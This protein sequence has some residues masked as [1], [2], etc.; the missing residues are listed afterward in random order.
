MLSL[1]WKTVQCVFLGQGRSSI[2]AH[3][4][5]PLSSLSWRVVVP[6]YRDIDTYCCHWLRRDH[7][8]RVWFVADSKNEMEFDQ[9]M[10]AI[11]STR[12]VLFT[13]ANKQILI[14]YVTF[15]SIQHELHLNEQ[16]K[17]RKNKR[18]FCT[19]FNYP[20]FRILSPF[21]EAFLGKALLVRDPL[22]AKIAFFGSSGHP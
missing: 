22:W 8:N 20:H 12:E 16:L 1:L 11:G 9:P 3:I 5:S 17:M 13:T 15:S 4:T 6:C 14:F 18:P 21:G 10:R 7:N 2:A 19:H